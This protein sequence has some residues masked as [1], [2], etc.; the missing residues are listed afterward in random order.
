MEDEYDRS[1]ERFM[2]QVPNFE[3][4]YSGVRVTECS[5][6]TGDCKLCPYHKGKQCKLTVC[7][8]VEERMVEGLAKRYEIVQKAV[9]NIKEPSFVKRF[10]NFI[11]ESRK[12]D[13]VYRSEK[14]EKVF[15]EAIEKLDKNNYGLLSAV[16]L[17]TADLVLWNKVRY[18][19]EKN[20]I[21]YN[22]INRRTFTELNYTLFCVS[23]DLYCGTKHIT[24]SDLGDKELISPLMF[25]LITNAMA[26][27]RY[28]LIAVNIRR[29]E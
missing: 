5:E 18:F 14:H 4:R 2:T 16:Y 11:T 22:N 19:V 21:L 13:M 23:M 6:K 8:Y 3:R 15:N 27:R 10:E 25:T 28:G 24:V 1:I 9:E 29:K 17:L 7:P 20:R 26:I 12:K